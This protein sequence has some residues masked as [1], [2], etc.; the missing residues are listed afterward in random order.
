MPQ[1]PQEQPEL[2]FTLNP[3][4][5]FS[6]TPY[7]ESKDDNGESFSVRF[8]IPPQM[9]HMAE[10][11]LRDSRQQGVNYDKVSDIAKDG[12]V[13]WMELM[14][15]HIRDNADDEVFFSI[16]KSALSES[17]A[18]RARITL[19]ETLRNDM[20]AASFYLD[21]NGMEPLHNLF[22]RWMLTIDK[23]A[24]VQPWWSNQYKKQ[25]LQQPTVR[26]GLT[27]L[28]ASSLAGSPTVTKLI[29]W[30]EETKE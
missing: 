29:A 20:R 4:Q 8:N 9:Y 15:A 7:R 17:E 27:M 12:F 28:L 11:L 18:E 19:A 25:F 22:T 14:S 13:K 21:N 24:L 26:R 1:M 2:T 3:G 10:S 5:R 23:L 30:F 16:Q 6:I